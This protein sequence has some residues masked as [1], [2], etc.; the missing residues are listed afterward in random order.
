MPFS[1]A[2]FPIGH[3]LTSPL[4]LT[5]LTFVSTILC[6][7]SASNSGRAP[8][9]SST[10]TSVATLTSIVRPSRI[11][12]ISHGAPS[13]ESETAQLQQFLTELNDST[14]TLEATYQFSNVRSRNGGVSLN[15]NSVGTDFE[16]GTNIPPFFTLDFAYT[17]SHAYGVSPLGIRQRINEHAISFTLLQP[18]NRLFDP[19]WRPAEGSDNISNNQ[20]AVLFN[21]NYVY[22]STSL[23]I[24][25]SGS[26]H[27]DTN[28]FL[29]RGLLDY[30]YTLFPGRF[31]G[32][33]SDHERPYRNYAF[34]YVDLS[35]GLRFLTSS[36]NSSV[37][38]IASSGNQVIY[39]N[40]GLVNV[41]V[42]ERIGLLLAVE[43]DAGLSAF[44]HGSQGTTATF[45]GGITY[46]FNPGEI[47][48]CL[49]SW[50]FG[51][52][53]SY[54]AFD[55]LTETNQLQVQ[56]SFSF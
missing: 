32:S 6:A 48:S 53:Y 50:H 3:G 35:S 30:Q 33:D 44:P 2:S 45:S 22:S 9:P 4:A 54:T 43:C 25:H 12:P 17:Y 47:D 37:A 21:A 24:P 23:Q 11:Q 18:V 13:P 5:V 1:T 56:A 46:N 14:R 36:S 7:Q 34:L 19:W 28:A 38:E 52:I 31:K 16:A 55:P 41:S 8:A 20:L 42:Y 10:A 39:E 51:L 29:G 27:A 26:A 15:I 40:T 49:H